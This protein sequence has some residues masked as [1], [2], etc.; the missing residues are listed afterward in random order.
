[1]P[2]EELVASRLLLK[3]LVELIEL[4]GEGIMQILLVTNHFSFPGIREDRDSS[5]AQLNE[6]RLSAKVYRV[7]PLSSAK[8][9][10]PSSSAP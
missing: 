6:L 10:S 9:K 7:L 1:M 2:K 4:P 8:H 3:A 5:L